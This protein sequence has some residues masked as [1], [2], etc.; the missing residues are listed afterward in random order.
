VVRE[1]N[2]KHGIATEAWS[3]LARGRMNEH[4][5]IVALEA[6]HGKSA[7]QIVLRWHIQLG[8][9]VIPKTS[10][11]ERLSQNIDVFDFE[12]DANDMD[13]M[14]ALDTGVRTGLD[15]NEF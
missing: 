7:A 11:P 1:F 10:N 3:P 15:P 9:L 12:L 13:A 6:K 14:L 5:T 2:A 4:P 8:N